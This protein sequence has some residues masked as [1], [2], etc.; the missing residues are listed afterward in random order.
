MTKVAYR[1]TIPT[2]S[3]PRVDKRPKLLTSGWSKH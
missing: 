2:L 3:R 1:W